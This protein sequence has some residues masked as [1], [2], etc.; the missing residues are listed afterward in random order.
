M[1]SKMDIARTASIDT[2]DKNFDFRLIAPLCCQT[3]MAGPN[4]LCEISQ[5]W[6]VF[7]D[8]PNRNAASSKK[9]TVGNTG[10]NIPAKPA[11]TLK[12]PSDSQT[13]RI[14]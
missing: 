10:R 3:R 11:T 12:L 8:F 1:F 2:A 6:A 14:V 4:A 5:S 7:E 13:I 9:G